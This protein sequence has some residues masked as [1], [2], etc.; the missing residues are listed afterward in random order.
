MVKTDS[1]GRGLRA[2]N[3]EVKD[4]RFLVTLG[5]HTALSSHVHPRGHKWEPESNNRKS[6]PWY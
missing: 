2:R 5:W 1:K 3:S 6:R 4:L